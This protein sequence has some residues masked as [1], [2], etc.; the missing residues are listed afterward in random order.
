MSEAEIDSSVQLALLPPHAGRRPELRRAA[1][2]LAMPALCL[3]VA[4]VSLAVVPS[5]P[6]Y[7]PF[8]WIVWGSELAH[9]AIGPHQAFLTGGGPSWKPLPVLFTTI[10]GIFG[11]AAPSLWIVFA[12]AVGLA[13]LWIAY[14]LGSRLG[15]SDRWPAGGVVAGLLSALGCVLTYRWLHFMFHATSEPMVIAA[16][17]LAVERHLAGRR[18]TAFLAGVALALLRP[19]ATPLVGLYGLWLLATGSTRTRAVVI[20]GLLLIP[21][22][23]I[24]P[25][26]LSS[27]APLLASR[28]ARDFNGHLGRDPLVTVLNRARKLTVWPVIVAAGAA[29]LLA[30]RR[31]ERMILVLAAASLA[32]VAIVAAMALD[33]YPGLERFML[34]AAAVVAVLAGVGVTRVAEL[35]GGGRRAAVVAAGL[36]AVAVPF[37]MGRIS[38]ETRQVADSQLA[39]RILN[40]TVAAVRLAGGATRMLPCPDSRV[41]INHAIQPSLAWELHVPLK[42]VLPVTVH[43]DSLWRPALFLDAPEKKVAGYTPTRLEHGLRARTVV[44]MDGWRVSRII[45]PGDASAN[46]CVG[47]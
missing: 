35:A 38:Y 7:D 22:A 33:H 21:A 5:V 26:W 37:L 10:F 27:H 44:R 6:G 14:R 24:V 12:R 46:A 3:L 25:P 9:L 45:R 15:H 39:E 29:V 17:L 20:C 16:T 43:K 28:H 8:S 40:E 19:E 4:G 23:W 2:A 41:A 34:P 30:V 31:G 13:G 18:L 47:T 1:M 42:D 36:V 11:R 32:Y